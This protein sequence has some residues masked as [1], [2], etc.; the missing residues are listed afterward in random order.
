MGEP[1]GDDGR[2][3]KVSPGHHFVKVC[4]DELTELMGPVDSSLVTDGAP[5]IIMMVGL[6]GS[7]KTTTAGK[8]ARRL[9]HEGLAVL[10]QSLEEEAGLNLLG[11]VALRRRLVDALCTRLRLIELEKDGW[12]MTLY[13]IEPHG[14]IE[15]SSWLDEY[16][17]ILELLGSSR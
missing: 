1:G 2:L 15:P 16:R 5:A 7:G 13:P 12:N 8:L 9:L 10:C 3:H 6:Q 4:Q 14:F 17:R 11:R